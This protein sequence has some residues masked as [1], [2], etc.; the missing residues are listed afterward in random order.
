MLCNNILD[1]RVLPAR[2]G[3]S[4]TF[5]ALVEN[6]SANAAYKSWGSYPHHDFFVARFVV[7]KE[8]IELGSNEVIVFADY[9]DDF[10]ASFYHDDMIEIAVKNAQANFPFI[11]EMSKT[12]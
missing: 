6:N 10:I 7:S 11:C 5:Y 9:Y 2:H 8:G 3:L 1:W 12:H 4:L